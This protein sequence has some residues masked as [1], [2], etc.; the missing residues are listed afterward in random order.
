M[1]KRITNKIINYFFDFYY[2]YYYCY[3][4]YLFYDS[5]IIFYYKLV[6]FIKFLI[7]LK[8]HYSENYLEYNND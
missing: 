5:I 3:L 2:F 7:I 4:F 8:R 6:L 1:I